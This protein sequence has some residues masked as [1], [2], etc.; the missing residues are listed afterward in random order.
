MITHDEGIDMQAIIGGTQS[1]PRALAQKPW[2]MK[3]LK[4]LQNSESGLLSSFFRRNR[5][6]WFADCFSESFS[7][8]IPASGAP[9]LVGDE[10]QRTGA[11]FWKYMYH[12]MAH[13]VP[14]KAVAARSVRLKAAFM[15]GGLGKCVAQRPCGQRGVEVPISLWAPFST[16]CRQLVPQ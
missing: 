6:N 8:A 9:T 16:L 7:L 14:K 1:V 3:S 10:L 13:D 2:F 4:R 5:I 15:L 11:T 12:Q